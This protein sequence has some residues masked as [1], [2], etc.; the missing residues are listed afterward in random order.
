MSVFFIA[1]FCAR[2]GSPTPLFFSI[3]L[4]FFLSPLTGDKMKPSS[5]TNENDNFFRRTIGGLTGRC[6]IFVLLVCFNLGVVLP[7]APAMIE[8]YFASEDAGHSIQCTDYTIH[9]RP[10]VCKRASSRASMYQITCDGL[11]CLLA[12]FLAPGI[13]ARSDQV[14]RKVFLIPTAAI[15]GLPTVA[16]L[17]CDLGLIG[18]WPYFVTTALSPLYIVLSLATSY[19]ADTLAPKDRAAG[20]G[21]VLG[22]FGLG[23]S[24]SPM[25]TIFLPRRIMLIVGTI[26]T[27]ITPMWTIFAMP[28][29]RPRAA[30]V[31]PFSFNPFA[32]LVILGRSRLFETVRLFF[33]FVQSLRFQPS[34]SS[35]TLLCTICLARD[36]S[37][38]RR[39]HHRR[40]DQLRLVLC[41]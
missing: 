8:N 2:R 35:H 1:V 22:G 37:L 25:L 15:M 11:K 24:M 4:C 21:M 41:D 12:F 30:K 33:F 20:F 40:D 38:A 32:P 31:S 10:A 23:I 17:L 9:N 14:G 27:A 16:L 29:S 36:D 28:E 19:A 7:I 5:R 13:G 39:D 3:F 6:V 18:L 26:V 34:S